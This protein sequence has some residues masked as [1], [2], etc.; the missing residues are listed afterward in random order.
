MAL[1]A[2]GIDLVWSRHHA[3]ALDLD[4]DHLRGVGEGLAV[5]CNRYGDQ[6]RNCDLLR[7]DGQSKHYAYKVIAREALPLCLSILVELSTRR[8][9][10]GLGAGN[11]SI[12]LTE[13]LDG[14]NVFGDWWWIV[15]RWFALL[16][17]AEH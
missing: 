2:F 8:I 12:N 9:H 3:D 15:Y 17:R 11:E 14:W 10:D 13:N 6:H 4:M 5:W 7:N 16:W 1:S